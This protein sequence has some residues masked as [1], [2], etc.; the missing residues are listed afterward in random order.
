MDLTKL[1]K[2]KTE[3]FRLGPNHNININNINQFGISWSKTP[4]RL[5][6]IFFSYDEDESNK[7]NFEKK[8][9]DAK[10]VVNLWKMRDLTT[11]GRIQ[12]IKTYVISKFMYTCSVIHMPEQY[13]GKGAGIK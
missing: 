4:I 1:N 12:I 7:Y 13:T 10:S 11:I 8:I 2:E 5:L 6:G 3:G 9:Q